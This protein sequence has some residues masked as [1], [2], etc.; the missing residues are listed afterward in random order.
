MLCFSRRH[1]AIPRTYRPEIGTWPI[2][3]PPLN[4]QSHSITTLR[5]R[6]ERS[7]RSRLPIVFESS[8]EKTAKVLFGKLSQARISLA[9]RS[10]TLFSPKLWGWGQAHETHLP[11]Q[12][13]PE[14]LCGQHYKTITGAHRHAHSAGVR[15]MAVAGASHSSLLGHNIQAYERR[16]IL[17]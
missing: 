6:E 1:L 7:Q 8:M 14:C 15:D 11:W 12:H 17:V 2:S 5:G 10:E 9:W 3:K 4:L 13:P 16:L